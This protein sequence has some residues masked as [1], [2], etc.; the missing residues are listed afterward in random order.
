MSN[1]PRPTGG[2]L[3]WKL[4]CCAVAIACISVTLLVIRQARTQAAH[5]FATLRLR[6]LR[7]GEDSARLRADIAR[8]IGPAQL[9]RMLDEI[10]GPGAPVE[11]QP[12]VPTPPLAGIAAVASAGAGD[13]E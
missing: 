10:D 2:A 1:G 6:V 7:S 12:R 8:R 4:G 5:E 3:A 11:G 13:G 9:R